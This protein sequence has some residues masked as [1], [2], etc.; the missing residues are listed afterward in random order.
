MRALSSWRAVILTALMLAMSLTPGALGA[1]R[2]ASALESAPTARL[3]TSTFAP[4][5]PARVWDS[6]V[7]PG[8]TGRIGPG[9][10]RNVVVAGMG[11]VPIS[12]ATSVVLNVTAVGP[13]A[14]TF[15]TVWPT[16]EA[17][18]VSSNLNVPAGDTRANL[19]TVKV[20]AGGQVSVFNH[21]G[22]V[23]LLADVTGWYG[24]NAGHAYTSLPPARV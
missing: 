11:G 16:G 2:V 23:D 8:P 4:L 6:R 20:G 22:T 14:G 10:T 5:S 12:G 18:P 13:S 7:G 24:P 21:T 3:D 9:V 19:V 17:R 1:P 15:I